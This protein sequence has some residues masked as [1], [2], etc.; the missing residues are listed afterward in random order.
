MTANSIIDIS[1]AALTPLIAITVAYIAWQQYRINRTR[2]QHELYERRLAV[3]EVVRAFISGIIRSAKVDSDSLL[4]FHADTA[5]ADFLFGIDVRNHIEKLYNKGVQLL[6]IHD[7]L[8][9]E[10]EH[11]LPVGPER[12]AC[13]QQKSEIL[14]W[15]GSQ[16]TDTKALSDNK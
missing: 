4:K 8:Y 5:E 13:S 9:P 16:F 2:L 12:K 15:F 3:F 7:K 6:E 10:G 14:K 11:G 1:S